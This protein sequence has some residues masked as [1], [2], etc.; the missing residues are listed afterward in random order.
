MGSLPS[1]VKCLEVVYYDIIK[2]YLSFCFLGG[3]KIFK[4]LYFVFL[5]GFVGLVIVSGSLYV[6]FF[7]LG[8]L[9]VGGLWLMMGF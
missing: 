1:A 8:R 7:P 5:C 3:F 4:A 6:L 9:G 2:F